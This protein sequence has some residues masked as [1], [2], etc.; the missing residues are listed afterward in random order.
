MCQALSFRG[1]WI[2][3]LTA[4]IFAGTARQADAQGFIS[5][6]YGYNF[7]G[8]AGCPQITDCKD[9]NHNYGAAFGVLGGITGFEAEVSHTN[10]FFGASSNQSTS[11]LTFFGNFMLAPRFG[12]IQPY[13]VA[14]VGMMRTRLESAGQDEEENQFA[15]DAG[16]GLIGFFNSHIGVRGD[17]RYFHTAE[18]LDLSRFPNIPIRETKLDFGRVS[19]AM[20]FKF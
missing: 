18:V 11:V 6:F 7:G 10:D 13:G 12:P 17:A 1:S 20:I 8:D 3:I 9:K 19:V 5:P 14:G 4:V 16:G 15:W 2:Y